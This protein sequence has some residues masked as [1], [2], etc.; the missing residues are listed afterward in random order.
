MRLDQYRY[1]HCKHCGHKVRFGRRE[2]GACY[3]DTPIY[4][5][6]SFWLMPVMLLLFALLTSLVVAAE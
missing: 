4:N 3:Q 6:V 2:C 5:H 1:F